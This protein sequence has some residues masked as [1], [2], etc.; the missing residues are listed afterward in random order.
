MSDPISYVD[1]DVLAA[2]LRIKDTDETS[3]EDI[4]E[5]VESASRQVDDYCDR[6]FGQ[7]GTVKEPVVR[8]FPLSNGICLIHDLVSYSR[9]EFEAGSSWVEADDAA[10]VF[11]PENGP[12]LAPAKPYEYIEG[13]ASTWSRVRITGVWGW[14]AVPSQVSRAAK[15]QAIR[16]W[17]SPTVSLGVVGGADNMGV[18]RLSASLHPD[19]RSLLD[20]FVK[21]SIGG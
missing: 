8:S 16:L 15:L 14:P 3:I 13:V 21:V 2:R 10:L 18:L 5:I 12:S 17:K 7:V 11:Q 20:P 19:A 4:D 1:A 9:I 6:Y